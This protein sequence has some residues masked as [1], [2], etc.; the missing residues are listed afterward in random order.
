MNMTRIRRIALLGALSAGTGLGMTPLAQATDRIEWRHEPITVL[1]GVDVE[2]RISFPSPVKVGLPA[3]I[4][5]ILRTQPV[6]NTVYWK[7]LAPF[8]VTRVSIVDIASGE[9]FLIDLKA[10]KS[11]ASSEPIEIRLPPEDSAQTEDSDTEKATASAPPVTLAG[12]TRFASQ[13]SYAPSRMLRE[14]PGIWRVRLG[15]SEPVRLVGGKQAGAIEAVPLAAWRS[16]DYFVTTVRL[17][18][19]SLTP[20]T[21]DPRML[22]GHWISAT[23]QHGRLAAM[24]DE[25]DT[26]AVYLISARPFEESL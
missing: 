12:L 20:L 25:A 19:V 11:G 21:F 9:T 8:T 3:N 14:A 2:R 16:R 7:A 4:A 13:Q 15:S 18:N 22:R 6:G 10:D 17:R 26:T 1:L 24:G 5:E 23:P